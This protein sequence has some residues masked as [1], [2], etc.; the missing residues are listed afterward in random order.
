MRTSRVLVCVVAVGLLANAPAQADL[1][2]ESLATG[3]TGTNIFG[4]SVS[5]GGFTFTQ[6]TSFGFLGAWQTG[7][8]D[9][10]G[11]TALL[12]YRANA[13]TRLTSDSAT[14]FNLFSID[15]AELFFG[16][17]QN[18][19]VTFTG[20]RA[21]ASV[22]S[23]SFQLD[24]TNTFSTTGISGFETFT[25][26]AAWTNLVKV[27]WAQV[28]QFHQFDNVNVVPVPAPGAV[29]LGVMGLGIVGLRR[30]ARA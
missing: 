29:L 18:V 15:L 13:N 5:E 10:A 24:G 20:T 23:Q 11:S 12:N 21:D 25:F 9:F 22:I 16:T 6:L 19:P 14:P 30:R 27:E 7:R 1:T 2:F 17:G 8:A 26:S 4:L 28:S 3:G